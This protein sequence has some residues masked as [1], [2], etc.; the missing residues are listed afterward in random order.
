MCWAA[1]LQTSTGIETW[2]VRRG[3][4]SRLFLGI[5][6]LAD[7][8]GPEAHVLPGRFMEWRGTQTS[9]ALQTT[10]VTFGRTGQPTVIDVCIGMLW[11]PRSFH[12]TRLAARIPA[13]NIPGIEHPTF[14]FDTGGP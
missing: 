12:P 2:S 5:V 6:E 11:T 7:I 9:T 10:P 14:Y 4:G 1:I 13:R 8:P 3:L